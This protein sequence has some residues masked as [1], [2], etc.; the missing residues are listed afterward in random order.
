M[1]MLISSLIER[2]S[3]ASY[4]LPVNTRVN[5]VNQFGNERYDGRVLKVEGNRARVCW[6]KGVKTDEYLSDLVP[7]DEDVRFQ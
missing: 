6:P 4:A 1:L 7:I 5:V 2:F 3:G